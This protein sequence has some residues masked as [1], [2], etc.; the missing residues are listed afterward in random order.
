MDIGIP[1]FII[2]GLI[3]AILNIMLFFKVWRMTNDIK[4]LHKLTF[5]KEA[6]EREPK[7][8]L[9]DALEKTIFNENIRNVGDVIATRTVDIEDNNAK[10]TTEKSLDELWEEKKKK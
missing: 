8:E 2:L 5:L 7:E 9:K 1:L 4:G 3:L 10:P 6:I